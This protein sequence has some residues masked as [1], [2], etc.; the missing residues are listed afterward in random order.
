VLT[1]DNQLRRAGI[2]FFAVVPGIVSV[3]LGT[4]AGFREAQR[5]RF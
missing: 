4:I 2:I 1:G 3:V 5:R